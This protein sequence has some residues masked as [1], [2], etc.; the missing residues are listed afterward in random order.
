M[1]ISLIIWKKEKKFM[2]SSD[3]FGLIFQPA[4]AGMHY[5]GGCWVV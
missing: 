4:L 3:T 2:K 5:N 1:A